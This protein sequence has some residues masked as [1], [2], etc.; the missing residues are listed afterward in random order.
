MDSLSPQQ[1]IEKRVAAHTAGDFVAIYNSAHSASNFRASFPD[2]DDYLDYACRHQLELL[3]IE[4]FA[5]EFLS[6]D[7]SSASVGGKSKCVVTGVT[8]FFFELHEL[9]REDGCWRLLSSCRL[10]VTEA[11]YRQSSVTADCFKGHPWF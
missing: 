9:Q 5:V 6:V 8:E 2:V 11:V 7:G 10:V 3:H 4:A 1:V